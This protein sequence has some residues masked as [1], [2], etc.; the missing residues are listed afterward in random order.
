MIEIDANKFPEYP[1]ISKLLSDILAENKDLRTKLIY[2]EQV[3]RRIREHNS[4]GK[5]LK[6]HSLATDALEVIKNNE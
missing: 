4:M 1:E 5:S 3:L 6:I 2:I